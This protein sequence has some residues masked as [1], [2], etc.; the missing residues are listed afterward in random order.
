MKPVCRRVQKTLA[1]EGPR[2]LRPDEAAQAHLAECAECY[3]VLEAL[4]EMDAAFTELPTTDAPDEVVER[5]LARR[6]LTGEDVGVDPAQAPRGVGF[7]GWLVA[8]VGG[9]GDALRR[10]GL[11]ALAW[12]SRGKLRAEFEQLAAWARAP[13]RVSLRRPPLWAGAAAVTVLAVVMLPFV[14]M[15]RKDA[16]APEYYGYTR[17]EEPLPAPVDRLSAPGE[18]TLESLPESKETRRRVGRYGASGAPRE[19]PSKITA[20]SSSDS[21]KIGKLD[22][23]QPRLEADYALALTEPAQEVGR[24]SSGLGDGDAAKDRFDFASRVQPTSTLQRAAR[25]PNASDDKLLRAF[26]KG[27]T[28]SKTKADSLN[29]RLGAGQTN[30]PAFAESV[31]IVP[32]A[33]PPY[34]SM[35]DAAEFEARPMA[36]DKAGT[37]RDVVDESRL[38]QRKLVSKEEKTSAARNESNGNGRLDARIGMGAPVA[39]APPAELEEEFDALSRQNAALQRQKRT[40]RLAEGGEFAQREAHGEL[41]SQ[42]NTSREGMEQVLSEDG[43]VGVPGGVAG[44]VPGGVV[45]A[46]VG[47]LP[48][49]S[50]DRTPGVL[51]NKKPLVRPGIEARPTAE[52][53]AFLAQRARVEGVPFQAANGY[54]AN[55]YVPGDPALRLLR[56]RLLQQ[57]SGVFRSF[58]T[59]PPR[60]HAAAHRTVQPLDVPS[61]AALAVSLQAD[62][63]GLNERGRLLVQVGLRGTPRSGGRRPAMN[64]ALVLDLRGEV[65]AQV[66]EGMRALVAAVGR[67]KSAG[68][69]FRLVVAGRPG[70]VVLQP[71]E[72][73]H[74]PLVVTLGRLLSEEPI[75]DRPTLGLVQAVA[76]AYQTLGAEDDPSAPLGSSLLLLVTGQPLGPATPSLVSLAHRGAVDGVPLSVVAVGRGAS[77]DEIDRLTLAGQGRRRLLD[78]PAEAEDLVDRELSAVSRVIARAVRL[79]IRLAPGVELVE[80][81]GSRRLDAARA[82]RVREAEQSIDQR[83]SRALGIAADRG[84]DEDGVQ[85]VLP[86]FEAGDHHAVLLDVVAPGAGPI[87]DVTVRYKDLV[88]LRNGVARASL[89]LGRRS[90]PRG[91]LEV[92]VWKTLLAHRLSLSLERAGRSVAAGADGRALRELRAARDLLAGMSF[93]VPTLAVDPEMRADGT[94][95]AE[96][97]TLLEA[98]APGAPARRAHLAD[99]LSYASKLKLLPHPEADER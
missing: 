39:A 74:G 35:A 67:A 87:A 71:G 13:R 20:E 19:A 36:G 26:G 80:V 57:D 81:I 62:R 30:V 47:G 1:E 25:D 24:R 29:G 31:E 7:G 97:L 91:P 64:V 42:A 2:G 33:P 77:P 83:L 28:V 58:L 3:A 53:S 54:W 55:T 14:L 4:A 51:G 85:I 5:L 69:R 17:T 65:P 76:V 93:E 73:R 10:L 15:G 48:D 78:K 11:V 37:L 98:K 44:G 38:A 99:S 32:A 56:A 9:L 16:Q 59:S 40:R 45:G 95:L 75:E 21:K 96:Y 12:L 66:A 50:F 49:A 6:E 90:S 27:S 46:I 8:T 61:S 18:S 82:Q 70:A 92:S 41:H 72:F 68:D 52:A 60:L 23:E 63:R 34:V 79:R 94:M 89:S 43:E 88:Y 86:H 22:S 84:E